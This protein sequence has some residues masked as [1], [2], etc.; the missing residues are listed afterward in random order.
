MKHPEH[1]Y[2]NVADFAAQFP[3]TPYALLAYHGALRLEAVGMKRRGQSARS[4][5]CR[6]LGIPGRG[7]TA[8]KLLSIY[9]D[10][11]VELGMLE[12]KDYQL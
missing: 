1:Y 5:V 11:L 2:Q 6:V 4:T 10:V 3:T 12:D 9:T 8:K 7:P